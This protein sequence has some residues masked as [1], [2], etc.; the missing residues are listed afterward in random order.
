ML[1]SQS[2][3]FVSGARARVWNSL[4]FF[5]KKERIAL[6]LFLKEGIALFAPF[7]RAI[8]SLLFF[9]KAKP[10]SPVFSFP[11]NRSFIK[12]K[13]LLCSKELNERVAHFDVV[14]LIKI[15]M[16]ANRSF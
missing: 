12:S 7:K 2:R 3:P 16:G 5:Y 11:E 1:R 4:G 10:K 8:H 14:A 13:S 15:A 9:I 6:S